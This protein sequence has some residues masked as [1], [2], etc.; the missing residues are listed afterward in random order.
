MK[1]YVRMMKINLLMNLQYR[2]AAY[3]GMVTQ[4]FWGIMSLMMFHAFYESNPGAFPMGFSQLSSYIW[5]QQAFLAMFFIYQ[6][7]GGIFQN[8]LDG[9]VAY[10]LCRPIDLYTNWLVKNMGV[11]ISRAV[12]R[13]IPILIFAALLPAPYGLVMP[14]GLSSFFLFLLSFVFAFI[15]ATAMSMAIYISAFFT[16]SPTGIRILIIALSDFLTGGIIPLPFFPPMAQKIAELL[17]FGSMQNVPLRIYSGEIPPEAALP[18]I[19]IQIVWIFAIILLGKF[20]IGLALKRVV[21]QGG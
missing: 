7:D 11:R 14:P 10:E 5:L 2:A 8:I 6:T 15:V 1:K 13:S 19:L 18:V 9:N 3:G 21:I 4:F 17:P 16:I 20:F 12:L